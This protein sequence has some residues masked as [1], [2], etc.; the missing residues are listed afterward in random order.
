MTLDTL[1]LIR[2]ILL[3]SVV[4][5]IGFAILLAAATF[6]GWNC[7]IGMVTQMFHTTESAVSNLVLD[8]FTAIR[9]FLVFIL[10]TPALAIHWTLKRE[11][12]RKAQ[13]Q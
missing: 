3:R 11:G 8:F 12:A 13:A 7:W 6:G 2:N 5:G 4:V 9:F 10:L 1:R